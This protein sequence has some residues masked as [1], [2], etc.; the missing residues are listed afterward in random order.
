MSFTPYAMLPFYPGPV[1]LYPAV[2]EALRADYGPPRFGVDYVELYKAT[3]QQLQKLCGSTQE[4]VMPTGEGMLA[5]WSALKCTLKPGDGVVT[6]GTGVFGDGFADMALS[7]GCVVEKIS[8]PYNSTLSSAD[9]EKIDAAIHRLNPVMLT[10]V[11]C[12]TPSG[13]LNPLDALGTLKKDRNVPLL[14]VDAV[15]SIGGAPVHGDAWNVDLLLGGAQKC[16]GCPADMSF[17]AV[18]D[19]AWERIARIDYQGYEAL[20]PFHNADQDPMRFPYTPNWFG[21]AALHA[22]SAALLAEGLFHV[23]ARHENVA[24]ICRNGLAEL[25]IPL[26]TAPDAVNSPTVTAACV[27]HGFTWPEWKDA[28]ARH[29]LIVGGSLGPMAGKVFRLGHMGP[30]ADPSRMTTA[31][32]VMEEVLRGK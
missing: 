32:S 26:W 14:V 12:E 4:V 17:L 11:H 2:N 9:L 6:V 5:L 29:S 27:P 16:L 28:L 20:L 25:N 10:A 7:L 23:F 24:Q 21:V 13:T 3:C 22:A 30:Q 18:S 8:L 1:S 19:T 15:A 31:I